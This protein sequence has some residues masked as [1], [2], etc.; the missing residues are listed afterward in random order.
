MASSDGFAGVME[1]QSLNWSDSKVILMAMY[2]QQ[3]TI[4]I[5]G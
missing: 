5:V 2:G 1:M 3:D 4:V